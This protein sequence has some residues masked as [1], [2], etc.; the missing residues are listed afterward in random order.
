[1]LEPSSRPAAAPVAQR[2]LAAPGVARP[3]GGP[4]VEE[5]TPVRVIVDAAVE[6]TA[7]GAKVVGVAAGVVGSAARPVLRLAWRPPVLPERMWPQT[8]VQR[9]A[10]AGRARRA[11]ADGQM[12]HVLDEAV[13]AIADAIIARLDLDAI[14]DRLNLVSIV[15]NVIEE[16]DLPAII[17]ESSGTMA[18][19]AVLDVRMRGIE[20]DETVNRIVDRI[21]R[22]RNGLRAP[23]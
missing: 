15:N 4:A 21:L 23:T 9:L 5:P 20:A 22:R 3:R 19:D 12:A 17:R 1:V 13:P 14:L 2:P 7:R 10:Q 11:Q 18:S 8:Q 6:V 16:I